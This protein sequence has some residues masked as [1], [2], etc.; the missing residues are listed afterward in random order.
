MHYSTA[1]SS[2]T[3]RGSDWRDIISN[4]YFPLELR[5][6]D[7]DR[8][9]GELDYWSM[10]HV[11]LSRIKC[12][13]ILYKR[14]E[15]QI[16]TEREKSFLVTIPDLAEVSFAQDGREVTCAPGGFVLERGDAPY[17]FCH[18]G[19][20]LLWVFKV[21]AAALRTRVGPPERLSALSFDATKGVGA[22]FVDAVRTSARRINEMDV[23]AHEVV[24]QH[25][26]DLLCLAIQ[27]DERVL[28]SNLSSV[29]SAH[30]FR[31]EQFIRSHLNKQEL[32]P[33]DIADSC[34]IS[35]RY[36]QRL[37]TD[38]GRSICEWIREQR[39]LMCDEELRKKNSQLT[40]SEIA[41]NW[42]FS[43]Q[44][45]FSKHY[46]AYFARSPSEAR[47]QYRQQTLC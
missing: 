9:N 14:H 18:P 31:A 21:S 5:Y 35:L 32:L 12:D 37:F 10:G 3:S 29:R 16:V 11:S 46:R 13:A 26:I 34:G 38:S 20:N 24:G 33:Q 39:L 25:L 40:I 44:S 22:Y 1:N 15:R 6:R 41:Y 45:Q 19:A 7:E 27:G 28:N 42:G 47:L 43:D 4:A 8:F 17:E 30:L 36:L 2:P 23:A